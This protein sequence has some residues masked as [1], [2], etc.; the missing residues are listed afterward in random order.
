MRKAGGASNW[1]RCCAYCLASASFTCSCFLM[2]WRKHRLNWAIKTL[3]FSS[4]YT[5]GVQGFSNL[6]LVM[7]FH[8]NLMVFLPWF[9]FRKVMDFHRF[10]PIFKPIVLVRN[11]LPGKSIT[12]KV[13]CFNLTKLLDQGLLVFV[14]WRSM[15]DP[16]LASNV[17]LHKITGF[18]K[19]W[20]N[21]YVFISKKKLKIQEHELE[22][23]NKCRKLSWFEF[24]KLL[25]DWWDA[26]HL[27]L[28]LVEQARCA[29]PASVIH[30]IKRWWFPYEDFNSGP[31]LKRKIDSF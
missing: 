25:V 22:L 23:K 10:S 7:V 14:R 24:P 9:F 20:K 31:K 27:C 1:F 3:A 26:N 8:H 15:S 13:L 5:F 28:G 4:F 18:W 12:R 2:S 16:P 6:G 29:P 11:N 30:R 17:Y 21:L 19:K